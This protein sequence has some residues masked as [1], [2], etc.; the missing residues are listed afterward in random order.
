MPLSHVAAAQ[1]ALARKH[2]DSEG[3][4]VASRFEAYV[5]G[6]ELANG[7]SG[8]LPTPQ[9]HEWGGYETWAARSSHLEIGAEPKIRA[10]LLKLLG[11]LK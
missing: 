11:L 3:G 9:G 1:A 2:Q 4:W 8:Y 10:M 7:Y 5:A 6:I